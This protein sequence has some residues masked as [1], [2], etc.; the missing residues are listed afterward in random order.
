MKDQNKQLLLAHLPLH[1]PGWARV[2]E[3]SEQAAPASS[4][5]L[6][7]VTPFEPHWGLYSRVQYR[8][9]QPVQQNH[10]SYLVIKIEDSSKFGDKGTP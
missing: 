6:L 4:H 5:G 2:N 1:S 8:I 7:Y 9:G 10:I 3:G